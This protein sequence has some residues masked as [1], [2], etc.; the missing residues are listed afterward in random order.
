MMS[1]SVNEDD[2]TQV[3]AQASKYLALLTSIRVVIL[4]HLEDP[5]LARG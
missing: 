2:I 5:R 1:S 3:G 4:L